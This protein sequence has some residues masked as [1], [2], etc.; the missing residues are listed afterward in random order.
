ML[1]RPPREGL[2]NG[3]RIAASPY[4]SAHGRSVR[5]NR[6]FRQSII[7][8]PDAQISKEMTETN[9]GIRTKY[10]TIFLF[11]VAV[12]SLRFMQNWLI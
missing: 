5:A 1:E 3:Q 7:R 11:V 10:L 12:F 2:S 6:G 9:T 4:S 8:A